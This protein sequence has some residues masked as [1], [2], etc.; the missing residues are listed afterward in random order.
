MTRPAA[1]HGTAS[2]LP[3]PSAS[4]SAPHPVPQP[5]GRGQ[6]R[7]PASGMPTGLIAGS[8]VL[9]VAVIFIIQN[10]Q[11]H[12][13]EP[14]GWGRTEPPGSRNPPAC[15]ACTP[16][17]PQ[18]H[19]RDRQAASPPPVPLPAHPPRQMTHE[20]KMGRP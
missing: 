3:S 20:K 5:P 4:G 11:A 17:R 16:R 14:S 19:T 2:T 12:H 1:P 13:V 10:A 7:T 8:A 15:Q 18:A 9:G 6:P